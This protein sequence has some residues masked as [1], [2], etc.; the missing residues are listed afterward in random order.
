MSS[1]E[2]QLI[3]D[4]SMTDEVVKLVERELTPLALLFSTLEV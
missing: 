3:R 1:A 2:E 4:K